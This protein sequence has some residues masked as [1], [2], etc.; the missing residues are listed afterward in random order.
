MMFDK[1]YIGLEISCKPSLAG[2]VRIS[3][4]ASEMAVACKRI[5]QCRYFSLF[6]EFVQ[7]SFSRLGK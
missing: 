3:F 4:L 7:L 5:Q 6:T 1:V 2:L